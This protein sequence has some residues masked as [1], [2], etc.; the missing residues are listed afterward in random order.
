L[1]SS[2]L[3][4]SQLG[5]PGDS[6]DLFFRNFAFQNNEKLVIPPTSIC[7]LLYDAV[8]D[9]ILKILIACAII[10]IIVAEVTAAPEDRSHAWIEG[11]AILIAVI[12]CSAV[13]AVNDYQK[14]K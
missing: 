14:E 10:S 7:R 5:I 13:T 2:L 3:T 1:L 6:E 11:F 9:F 8:D 4:H 12:V